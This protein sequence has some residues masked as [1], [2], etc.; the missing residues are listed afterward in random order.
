M[1]REEDANSSKRARSRV[2]LV[3]D[4]FMLLVGDDMTACNLGRGI[5]LG[6][7]VVVWA[8]G[9]LCCGLD[10]LVVR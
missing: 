4:G 7:F 8:G 2:D 10:K 6:G 9:H 3:G 5:L 1:A